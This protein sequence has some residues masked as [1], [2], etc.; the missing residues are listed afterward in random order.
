MMFGRVPI[1]AEPGAPGN[2]GFYAFWIPMCLGVAS[3]F[4]VSLGLIYACLMAAIDLWRPR[5]E[6]TRGNI[7]KGTGKLGAKFGAGYG[8]RLLCGAVAGGMIGWPMLHRWSA[9]WIV[10]LGMA[11]ALVSGFM[12]RPKARGLELGAGRTEL[13]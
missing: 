11:S 3:V 1:I 2:F 13:K 4:G 10:G 9:M 8:E 5:G 12:S 6:T 7:S